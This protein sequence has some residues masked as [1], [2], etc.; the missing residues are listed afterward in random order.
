LPRFCVSAGLGARSALDKNQST[1]IIYI[2]KRHN[3]E[4]WGDAIPAEA[5]DPFPAGSRVRVAKTGGRP[6]ERGW[7]H[8]SSRKSLKSGKA[9][10]EKIRKG[11]FERP[12]RI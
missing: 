1:T 7:I 5:A 4:A 8:Q 11:H 10:V 6:P 3:G 12:L 2:R 9:A